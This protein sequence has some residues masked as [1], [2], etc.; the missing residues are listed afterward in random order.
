MKL[1]YFGT[2][3]GTNDLRKK[4]S[5]EWGTPYQLYIWHMQRPQE[6]NMRETKLIKIWDSGLNRD[7]SKDKMQIT[8]TFFKI[9]N[10][11]IYQEIQIKLLYDFILPQSEW[12]NSR[13]QI[14]TVAGVDKLKGKT[15]SR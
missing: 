12:L 5:A 6:I 2:E 4:Q 11:L 13:I 1:R 8:E 9:L 15:N 7:F 3:N 14:K 10:N